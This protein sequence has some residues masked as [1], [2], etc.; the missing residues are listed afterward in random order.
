MVTMPRNMTCHQKRQTKQPYSTAVPKDKTGREVETK[1][2]PQKV[3]RLQTA[4]EMTSGKAL[5]SDWIPGARMHASL[6]IDLMG[7]QQSI[8]LALGQ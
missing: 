3:G 6:E 1:T 8:W 2:D 4:V 5:L 7:P